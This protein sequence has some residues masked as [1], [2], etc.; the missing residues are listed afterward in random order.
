MTPDTFCT[1]LAEELN[2]AT[3]GQVQVS[4]DSVDVPLREMGL[5]SAGLLTF[6]LAAE[7]ALGVSWA[8]ETPRSVFRSIRSMA[9][10]LA[11]GETQPGSAAADA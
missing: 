11:Q 5:D 4:A 10:F 9:E 1:L 8:P 2:K 3:E 7:Q 6:L